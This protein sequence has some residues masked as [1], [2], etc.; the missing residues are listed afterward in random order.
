MS[1]RTMN[2]TLSREIGTIAAFIVLFG[3]MVVFIPPAQ[4]ETPTV[5]I[6]DYKTAPAVM[7][8]DSMGTITVTIRNTAST[9][10]VS[11][12]TALSPDYAGTTRTTDIN[13][14]IENIHLE[15]KGV[16]VLTEDFNRIGDLG[17]GQSTTITF[18]IRAP[19]KSGMYF[20]E[21]WIDTKG[22]RSTRY[23]IPVNVNTASG[24]QKQAILILESSLPASVNPGDDI[25]VTLTMKNAGQLMADDVTLKLVNVSTDVAPKSTDLYHLGTIG[26]GSEKTLNIALLS[27]KDAKS[28]LVRVPVTV[29]YNALDGSVVTEQTGIDIMMKG[30]AELG[31]VS[32]DT[33]P[34]RLTEG[35]PFD[36]TI[37]VENTGTGEAKQVSAT[38]DLPVEGK[39]EAFIGKIKPGNDAPVIFLLEGAQGGNHPYNLTIT[40]T[41]D[42]GTHTMTRQMNLRV[43]PTDMTGTIVVLLIVLVILGFAGYRYWYLPKVNGDGKFPWERKS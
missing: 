17:P 15:E 26:A 36:L 1:E 38:I 9:A 42:M 25:P 30:K 28:G 32:V 11:E 40:Y 35:T 10:S 3:L 13:V 12:S 20:P 31:F 5:T 34:P 22:G 16:S 8:P 24:I 6:T 39:K 7:M 37:R 27:D 19:S 33:S 2:M 4:A 41:D 18:S 21:V 43:P 23:P 14:Y 29:S